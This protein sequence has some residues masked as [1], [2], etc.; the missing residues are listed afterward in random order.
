MTT[1]HI[2]RARVIDPS[3]SLDTVTDV[4]VRDGRLQAFSAPPADVTADTVI[5]ADEQWLLP[6]LVDLGGHLPE[7]G[8]SQKGSID[9]ETRA[10]ALGGFSHLCSL[11]DT[12]PVADT[13]AVI[14]LIQEKALRA[15]HARVLP[16][17]AMTQGLEGEQLASMVTLQEAG[18]VAMSNAR[19]PIRDS[20]VLR[21]LMEYAATYDIAL[22]L[23]A[24][25][26]SLAQGGCM[27]E[28]PVATRM[29]L[30]GIPETAETI[31]LAQLLL[32]IEQTGVRAHISQ[33]SCRRSLS[34][35]AQAREGGLRVT[36]DTPLANLLYTDA[37]V[38]GYNSL[39][40]VQ[41]PLRSEQDRDALRAAVGEGLLA[42]SSNHRPHE[43][44]AK[45]AP[46]ADADAGMS[47]YDGFLPMVM[48]LLEQSDLTASQ[49]IQATSVLPARLVGLPGGLRPDE[50]FHATL[51]N[52]QATTELSSARMAS[53]GHNHPF[54]NQSLA[55]AVTATFADG[56]AIA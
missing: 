16:L 29:G 2:Q 21:R 4:W 14:K 54:L 36:A 24:N 13:S 52:P 38:T 46:F 8:Y 37:A 35:L 19:Q 31:A 5:D 51:F 10:A 11:P 3:Q 43:I 50:A 56:L 27:H 41:P 23:N 9:S 44:A 17:G 6:A 30:S 32:L 55:G 33:I 26:L 12:K 1:L 20:Y 25:D 34:M 42:I 45:K 15:G 39:Y 18:A 48:S 28:G 47:Q 7:P 49:L 40:N 22:F 53:R